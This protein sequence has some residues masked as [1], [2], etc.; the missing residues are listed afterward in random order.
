MKSIG[1]AVAGCMLLLASSAVAQDTDQ[2]VFGLYYRCNQGQE[3]RADEIVQ[4]VFGPIAQRH[5]DAGQLTGWLW[6]SHSQ[7]G[8]WRRVFATVGTDMAVMMDVRAQIVEELTTQHA[9]AAAEL[10]SICPSHDDYIWTSVATSSP[11]PDAIAGA[12]LSTYHACD[13]SREGRANQIFREVLAP[14]YQK[15][16]DMGH[17]S[18][19]GFYAHRSGGRFRRL[20]TFSGAD[21]MTLMNMQAAILGEANENNAVA[22]Q[23]FNQ[24]CDWHVDYMWNNATQQ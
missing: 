18:S 10:G 19:W 2:I 11:D 24:I 6:L 1:V 12:T 7:G 4:E 5:V 16:M 22:M 17:L 9:E 8:S 20:E 23:E 3:T 13:R 21:H 14:L 15:H